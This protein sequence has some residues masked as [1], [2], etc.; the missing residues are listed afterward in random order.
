MIDSLKFDAD[1]SSDV[2]CIS[3]MRQAIPMPRVVLHLP[4]WSLNMQGTLA[5]S[6]LSVSVGKIT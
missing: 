5:G 1:L 2:I 3:L 6:F 4:C